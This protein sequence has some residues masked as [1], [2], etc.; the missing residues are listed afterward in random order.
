MSVS[1]EAATDGSSCRLKA[2][3]KKKKSYLFAPY[4]LACRYGLL[5]DA[6]VAFAHPT[7]V[8]ASVESR[9]L[10]LLHTLQLE[11]SLTWAPHALAC[12]LVAWLGSA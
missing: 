6:W 12:V 2:L 9:L 7:D 8:A 10:L 3:E 4:D 5:G 11:G 1:P